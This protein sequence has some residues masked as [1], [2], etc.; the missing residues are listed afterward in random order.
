MQLYEVEI[1]SKSLL[2]EG[3]KG[4]ITYFRGGT[5]EMIA[6]NVRFLY[7]QYTKKEDEAVVNITPISVQEYMNRLVGG[8]VRQRQQLVTEKAHILELSDYETLGN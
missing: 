8:V 4:L 6:S 2:K 5:P 1:K 7:P 3:K